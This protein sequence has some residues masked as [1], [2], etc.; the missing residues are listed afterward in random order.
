[1]NYFS[2][3][4][5]KNQIHKS[6][7]STFQKTVDNPVV[8]A[9]EVWNILSDQLSCILDNVVYAQWF[10]PVKPLVLNNNILLL[11]VKDQFSERWITT[12]YQELVDALLSTQD[13]KLSCFFMAPRK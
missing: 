12:H 10:I 4:N 2:E 8:R 9:D 3:E 5:L 11:Q 6:L 7:K 1:M 13:K